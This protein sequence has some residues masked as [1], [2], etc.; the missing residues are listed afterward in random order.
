MLL[1]ATIL[2]TQVAKYKHTHLVH[3]LASGLVQESFKSHFLNLFSLKHTTGFSL[4]SYVLR[5]PC[6]VSWACASM[7]V[8]ELSAMQV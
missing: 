6:M 8:L 7:V 5:V 3:D 2:L 1:L 4:C